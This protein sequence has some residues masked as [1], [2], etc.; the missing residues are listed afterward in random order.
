MPFHRPIP[1]K[2]TQPETSG[3][4]GAWVQAETMIQIALVMPCAAFI[5]WVIGAGLDRWLHQTWISMVGI[6]LGIIAG[7]VGAIQMAMV[8]TAGSKQ[9]DKSGDGTEKESSGDPS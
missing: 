4:L 3:L 8:Y 1:K 6:V 9:E 5:G 2:K 7:L